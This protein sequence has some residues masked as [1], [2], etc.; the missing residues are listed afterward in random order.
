M[1]FGLFQCLH[2][3]PHRIY[4]VPSWVISVSTFWTLPKSLGLIWTSV[5]DLD[6][7]LKKP[8]FCNLC[9]IQAKLDKGPLWFFCR[10]PLCGQNP[11]VSSQSIVICSS[12]GQNKKMAPYLIFFSFFWK[13]W[14]NFAY[15]QFAPLILGRK[16]SGPLIY[17]LSTTDVLL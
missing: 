4:S 12:Y 7:E 14:N 11:K 10:S 1:D 3:N 8:L 17:S 16:Q 2:S 15:V 9:Q 6:P 5:N 13:L